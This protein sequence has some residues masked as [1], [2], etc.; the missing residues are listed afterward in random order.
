MVDKAVFGY[1]TFALSLAS[2]TPYIISML[3]GKTRPH[4]FTYALWA[5]MTGINAAGQYA[6]H[7]G[8]GTISAAITAFFC[9][10]IFVL[11][12]KQGERVITK[13]DW[14]CLVI[15]LLAIPAWYV[16]ADPLPAVAIATFIDAMAYVPTFRKSYHKPHEEMASAYLIANA[17]HVA[18]IFAMAS[19][20]LTTLLYPVTLFTFNFV[21]IGMLLWRRKR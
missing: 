11:A 16:T 15:G 3:R 2:N 5:L 19:L 9:L 18:S 7:A 8:F 12:L 13:L 14:T 20:S 21:L 1:L 6:A 10:V 17:R 4:I